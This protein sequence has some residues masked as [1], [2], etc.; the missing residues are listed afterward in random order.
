MRSLLTHHYDSVA[1]AGWTPLRRY[2]LALLCAAGAFVLTA[3]LPEIGAHTPFLLYV[4]AV[5]AACFYGG[6]GPGALAGPCSA[7]CSRRAGS[8]LAQPACGNAQATL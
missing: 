1:A 3:L 8:R 4:I 2:G 6:F 5:A 7:S